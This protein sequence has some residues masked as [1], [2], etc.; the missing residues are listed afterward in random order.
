MELLQESVRIACPLA[1]LA[2]ENM[3]IS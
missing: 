1:R 3:G 2:A